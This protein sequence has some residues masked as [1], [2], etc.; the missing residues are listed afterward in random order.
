MVRFGADIN[1]FATGSNQSAVIVNG[2][3]AWRQSRDAPIQSVYRQKI[4]LPNPVGIGYGN[5]QISLHQWIDQVIARSN[6]IMAG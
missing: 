5:S 1:F 4:C 3:R 6:A 2:Q